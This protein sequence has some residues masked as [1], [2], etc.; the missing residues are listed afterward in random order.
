MPRARYPV[1]INK[2]KN[3]LLPSTVETKNVLTALIIILTGCTTYDRII[4]GSHLGFFNKCFIIVASILYKKV[5]VLDD[6]IFSV[7]KPNWLIKSGHIFKNITW[8]SY[9]YR[10]EKYGFVNSYCIIKQ[11][12]KREYCNAAI[13]AMSD[14]AGHGLSVC[15]EE[16]ILLFVRDFVLN[17]KLDL[18]LLPHRRA[19][20]D[21][22]KGLG[23]R[24]L[25]H[26]SLCFEDWYLTSNFK[27]CCIIGAFSSIW[28]ILED[29]RVETLLLDTGHP[30]MKFDLVS[31]KPDKII[32]VQEIPNR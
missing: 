15:Q 12:M 24:T 8:H 29:H 17:T 10:D 16:A 30:N 26:D 18:V 31:V 3:Y 14:F 5:I 27:N 13:F 28:Q 6:G 9:Y 7:R 20:H 25:E 22:Y 19:R 4:V 21:L 23:L 2:I 11:R 32:K 1:A